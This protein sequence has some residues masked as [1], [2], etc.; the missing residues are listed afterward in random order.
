MFFEDKRTAQERQRDLEM[1]DKMRAE[2]ILAVNCL[3]SSIRPVLER[4]GVNIG[5]VGTGSYSGA[6][7]LL[8][9]DGVTYTLSL[10]VNHDN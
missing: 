10:R 1:G 6:E 3:K 2:K 8:E 4:A 7:L 9:I 5:L